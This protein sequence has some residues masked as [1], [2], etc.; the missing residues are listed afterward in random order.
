MLLTERGDELW[1]AP[2]LTDNWLE[3]G[4]KIRVANAPTFFGPVSY[5]IV[6]SV[7]CGH[8]D[9]LIDPPTRSAPKA[10]VLRLRHPEG[11]PIKSVQLDTGARATF[12][13][14]LQIVRMAPS[15]GPI[16]VRVEY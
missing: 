2:L 7:D 12:D 9:A 4:M 1:L 8:I 11:R 14:T 3:D 6:S 10:I 16:R 15:A 13:N 5:Q